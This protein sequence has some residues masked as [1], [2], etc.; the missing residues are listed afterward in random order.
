[1]TRPSLRVG[2]GW[3]RH[4]LGAYVAADGRRYL[5]APAQSRTDWTVSAGGALDIG[6]DRLTLSAAHLAQHE[7]RTQLGALATDRPLAFRLDDARA[8]YD[9]T[10]GRWTVTPSVQVSSWR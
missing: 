9:V 8:S 1:G 2:S 3:S 4:A 6:R 10:A 5:D 7:D